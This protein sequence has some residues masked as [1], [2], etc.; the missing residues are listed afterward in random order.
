MTE[1]GRKITAMHKYMIYYRGPNP[2]YKDVEPIYAKDED[3]AKEFFLEKNP[4]CS[5]RSIEKIDD[6]K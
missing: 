6:F 2:D 1:Q 3:E 5:I 4:R